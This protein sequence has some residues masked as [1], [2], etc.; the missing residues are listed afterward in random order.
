MTGSEVGERKY[1]EIRKR[2]MRRSGNVLKLGLELGTPQEQ[3]RYM[4][5]R[6]P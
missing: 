2:N 3:M 5:V 1:E 6:C 4:S